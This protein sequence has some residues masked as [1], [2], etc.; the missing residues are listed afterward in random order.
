MRAFIEL[1]LLAR[2]IFVATCVKYCASSPIGPVTASSNLGGAHD[3]QSGA[4]RAR[5]TSSFGHRFL[6]R[7]MAHF[8]VQAPWRLAGRNVRELNGLAGTERSP[9]SGRSS[10]WRALVDDPQRTAAPPEPGEE[11]IVAKSG[12]PLA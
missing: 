11:I 9:V 6:L 4:T 5:M 3:V 10:V 7:L 8:F 1:Q 12:R 2:R